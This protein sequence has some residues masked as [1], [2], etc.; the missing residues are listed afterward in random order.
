MHAKR[1]GQ[2]QLMHH[3]TLVSNWVQNFDPYR[4]DDIFQDGAPQLPQIDC[5]LDNSQLLDLKKIER[6]QL[7]PNM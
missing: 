1:N 2:V 6:M 3:I 5:E 4:I 7:S